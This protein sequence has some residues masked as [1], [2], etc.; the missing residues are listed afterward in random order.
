MYNYKK[1]TLS[2]SLERA[3]LRSQSALIGGGGTANFLT[4]ERE[5]SQP[6]CGS[7][8]WIWKGG[9][10]SLSSPF[11]GDAS[12]WIRRPFN[13]CL[14]RFGLLDGSEIMMVVILAEM[15]RVSLT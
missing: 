13:I 9:D 5:V 11:L 4:L 1:M 14:D 12:G 8:S 6:R 2:L 3:T 15:A 7:A 10:V